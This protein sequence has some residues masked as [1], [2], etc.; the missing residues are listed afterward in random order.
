ME[1]ARACVDRWLAYDAVYG[2]DFRTLSGAAHITAV[3]TEA[4]YGKWL[5]FTFSPRVGKTHDGVPVLTAMGR[6]AR[7]VA[8]RVRRDRPRLPARDAARRPRCGELDERSSTSA[9]PSCSRCTTADRRG[10]GPSSPASAAR[11]RW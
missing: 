10:V 4:R 3:V 5:L 8:D 6:R 7:D 1:T 11:A 2:I 9:S